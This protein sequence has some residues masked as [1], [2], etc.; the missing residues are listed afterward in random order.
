MATAVLTPAPAVLPPPPAATGLLQQRFVRPLILAAFAV[1]T[2]PL[3]ALAAASENFLE[4]WSLGW[5]YVCALGTT[6]F[7]LTL[8]IYLQSSNLSYFGS[9]WKKR[10][11]YFLVPVLIFV[12]FD[13]YR[14]L[15]IA[16]LL[17]AVD[18]LV[19][20]GIR[21]LDFQHFNRQSFG[22]FQLFK[23]KSKEYPPW[24]RKVES[25]Y[26]L[27]LTLLLFFTFLSGGQ[28][29]IDNLW[30][31]LAVLFVLCFLVPLLVGYA[32]VWK[33]SANRSD[34]LFPF[35]YFLL[36]SCSAALA[37]ADNRFY[38]CCLAMHYVEYHVLMYPRCFHS[39]L[40]P[41]SRTDRLFARLRGNKVAF[42]AV[43]FGLAGLVTYCTWIGMGALIDREAGAP[44]AS[45]LALVSLFD[46]LFVFHYFIEMLIWKFSDPYYRQT[47]GPLY[48]G[49]S[50]SQRPLAVSR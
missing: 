14:A 26:F 8:T 11:L 47:L 50:A 39:R 43:L 3:C 33:Q 32:R 23:G 49:E 7:V 20:C 5:L 40:D 21:L 2:L 15:R 27:G 19:R 18:L 4:P 46:G 30:T 17:P 1:L 31:R 29:D 22:V 9:T 37:I 16:L 13:L 12:F 10:L 44:N 48:F 42:Y 45:Y 25:H 38:L 6:H 35:G 28:F 24:V 36:Q 34:L 41:R